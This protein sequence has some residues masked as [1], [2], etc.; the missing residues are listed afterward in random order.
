[1][2]PQRHLRIGHPALKLEVRASKAGL[3]I[4]DSA[5]RLVNLYEVKGCRASF[6]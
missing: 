6:G 4:L 3:R 1:M 2:R 5:G